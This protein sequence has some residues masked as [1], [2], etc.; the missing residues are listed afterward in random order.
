MKFNCENL[1]VYNLSRK[2]IVRVYKVTNEF[3]SSEKFGLT[4]Q[5][6]RSVISVCLNIAEGSAKGS[7]K[8]F[9]H[10]I[11]IALGSLIEMDIS[12]KI[13]IDLNFAKQNDYD[14]LDGLIKDLYF[15]LIGLHKSL[16]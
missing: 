12:L 15:K 10:F 6:H 11:K 7:K 16:R 14:D 1:D 8:D 9:A 3:P 2:L 4:S 5:I 13:A